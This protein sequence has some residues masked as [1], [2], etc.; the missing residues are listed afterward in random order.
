LKRL[1]VLLVYLCAFELTF[2]VYFALLWKATA[3]PGA[4]FWIANIAGFAVC[5]GSIFSS[6]RRPTE[7]I[8]FVW[9]ANWRS[10][11]F[12]VGSGVFWAAL[13]WYR[14]RSW[15]PVLILFFAVSLGSLAFD[16]VRTKQISER[17]DPNSGTIRSLHLSLALLAA[18]A[19]FAVVHILLSHSSKALLVTLNM[20]VFMLAQFSAIVAFYWAG[21]FVVENYTTRVLLWMGH[22]LP[23][24]S[25]HFF[26]EAA[27][28]LFLIQRGGS[29]EFVH[30]TFR[31]YFA[32]VHGPLVRS[33]QIRV[34]HP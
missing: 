6:N 30:P 20:V 21:D 8:T 19:S 18:S 22:K 10:T 25:I 29:Y 11:A 16:C 5:L 27:A 14:F 3:V 2:G 12:N 13:A 32:E 26:K 34:P 23:L 33:K 15:R 4:S 9:T 1:S 17:S 31:D 24:R 7:G 28:R